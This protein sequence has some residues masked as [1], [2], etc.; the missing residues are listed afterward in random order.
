M[1]NFTQQAIKQT[2]RDLLVTTPFDKITVSALVKECGISPNTFYY[3]YQDIYQLL[4]EWLAEEM[5]RFTE[6]EDAGGWINNIVSLMSVMKE[7]KA[8]I[9][10]IAHSLSRNHL[11]SYIF[12]ANDDVIDRFVGLRASNRDIPIEELQNIAS[13]CRYAVFGCI[14]RF[15][16]NDMEDDVEREADTLWRLLSDFIEISVSRFPLKQ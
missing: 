2:F 10:H 5:G 1:R 13:F 16:R 8:I 14:W 7:N 11:E 6:Q 9:N 4:D 12:N 15:I 3:H